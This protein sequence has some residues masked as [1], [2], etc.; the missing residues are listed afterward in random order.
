MGANPYG[1]LGN[2]TN[3]ATNRPVQIP[4]CVLGVALLGG[5]PAASGQT[6]LKVHRI[7]ITNI[8]PQATSDSLVRANIRVREGDFY[9]R[10]SIDDDVRNLYVTG[11]FYNI[12]VTEERNDDGV[13]LLYWLQG[14]PK[15]TDILSWRIWRLARSNCGCETRPG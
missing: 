1:E 5:V 3:T 7:A 6:L 14:K 15:L 11:F 8:G 12:R 9:S 13:D 10:N 4:G 2:G